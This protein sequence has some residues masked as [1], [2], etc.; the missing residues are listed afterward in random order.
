MKEISVVRSFHGWTYVIGV[1]RLHDDAGWGVFVTDIS[2]P[3]GER[4]DD[5]DDRDSAYESP[6]EALACANSLMR[7]AI[8]RA[9]T[10]PEN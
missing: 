4:M 1:S 8:Q 10:A 6:D 5:I 7:D 3:E 9:G 2:G